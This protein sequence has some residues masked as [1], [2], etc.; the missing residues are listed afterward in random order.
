MSRDVCV[1]AQ[2]VRFG[3]LGRFP[4]FDDLTLH[5]PSGWTGIVGGNGVGKTT[6]MRLLSGDLATQGGAVSRQPDPMVVARCPQ[7]V[8]QP[9]ELLEQFA[10]DWSAHSDQV[11]LA[12]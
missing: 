10:W 1:R 11:A 5:I 9:G 2:S 6:L 3:Y 8:A 4:L 7:S 12:L